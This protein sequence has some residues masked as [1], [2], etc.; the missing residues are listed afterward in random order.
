M[1]SA[2][3]FLALRLRL[4]FRDDSFVFDVIQVK[5]CRHAPPLLPWTLHQA[6][7][8]PGLPPRGYRPAQPRPVPRI[9]H[10][11]RLDQNSIS[12]RPIILK[13]ASGKGY[14]SV[15]CRFRVQVQNIH[16]SEPKRRILPVRQFHRLRANGTQRDRG[17]TKGIKCEMRPAH[18]VKNVRITRWANVR[19]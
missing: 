17:G 11:P 2:L 5:P 8:T 16:H 7:Q 15:R 4:A 18:P 1:R 13:W 6:A 3:R 19:G 14:T 9:A 10:N 12:Q